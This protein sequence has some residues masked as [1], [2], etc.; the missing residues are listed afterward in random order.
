MGLRWLGILQHD[1]QLI[2]VFVLLLTKP[3]V[4]VLEGGDFVVVLG[5][6]NLLVVLAGGESRERQYELGPLHGVLCL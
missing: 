4:F 6:A 2:G 5:N 3:G 1:E